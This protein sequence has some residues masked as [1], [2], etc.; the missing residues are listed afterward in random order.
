MFKII[1][2]Y[3]DYILY[4]ILLISIYFW[5]YRIFPYFFLDIPLWYDPGLYRLFFLDYYNN[6]P[7]ID[8]WNLSGRVK[9]A[10]PPFLWFF[11]NILQIIWFKV[12]FLLSFWLWIFSI[13]SSLFI[14]LLLRK[15]SKQTAIVWIIIFLISII[16]YQVFWWNYY[17][18]IIWILFMLVSFYLLEKKK[19]VLLIP[20]LISLFIT[21]KPSLVFFLL[22]FWIFKLLNFW[23]KWNKDKKDIYVVIL[24]GIL[25]FII[26]IPF[27]Q[28]QIFPLIHPL[29]STGLSSEKS[30]TFFTWL[31]FLKYNYLILLASILWF[32][33][34]IRNK[35]F[36]FIF[37]WYLSWLI[38]VWFRLFFYNRFYV[39][40]DIFAIFLAAYFFWILYNKKRLIFF[41]IFWLFFFFQTNFYYNYVNLNNKPLIKQNEFEYIKKMDKILPNDSILMVTNKTYSP[42]L[43][44]YTNFDIIAPWL[45][46]LNLWDKS[47]WIK[48]WKNDW[49]IK[50]EMINEY[51]NLDK[52]LYIWIWSMQR[53]ENFDNW[54]CF[55]IVE[56]KDWFT[57]LKV[58]FN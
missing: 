21:N 53:N 22:T 58:L 4:I 30:W 1:T 51:K 13:I 49:I 48:W 50:C 37:C 44:G 3:S 47:E 7:N 54:K 31:E 41:I 35:D 18:Q 12:D 25:S 28:V 27:F 8:F 19:Y 6:L 9:E 46:D 24:V 10:Y 26:Y 42:W 45:F 38:W 29:L 11:S 32:F 15:H 36:D 17:K 34:K 5:I 2:K 33:Y 56:K 20:I 16:Q 57:L 23:L 55:E 14:Y 40:F 39:F 43:V 52:Q